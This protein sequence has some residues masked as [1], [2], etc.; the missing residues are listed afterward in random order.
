MDTGIVFIYIFY[1]DCYELSFPF[2]TNK[3]DIIIVNCLE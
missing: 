1:F 2:S 3:T